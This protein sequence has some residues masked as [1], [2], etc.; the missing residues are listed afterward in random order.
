MNSNAFDSIPGNA[1]AKDYINI[2]VDNDC[3]PHALIIE[4]PEG[5]GKKAFARLIAASFGCDNEVRP[6]LC[7]DKCSRILEDISQDV[8]WIIPEKDKK[9]IGVDQIRALRESL[10]TVPGESERKF[11][12]INDASTMTEQAQNGLLKTIEEPPEFAYFLLL[13]TNAASLLP[14]VRSRAPSVRMQ[15]F[16]DMELAE[17]LPSLSK[18]ASE[19]KSSDPEAYGL[20]IRASAGCFEKALHSVS[21]LKVGKASGSVE[22]ATEVIALLES[23]SR[24]QILAC[25]LAKK[26]SRDD[27]CETVKIV[28]YALRDIFA[29]KKGCVNTPMLFFSSF[30]D[31]SDYTSSF[32]A[33]TVMK[34]YEAAKQSYLDLNNISLN[35]RIAATH[36]AD[37]LCNARDRIS[38]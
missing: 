26:P 32:T 28:C 7:C 18:K 25:L 38:F 4:G 24:A 10:Y 15:I 16:E 34:M 9:T 35:A 11:F 36:F 20:A 5:T 2:C 33:D 31:A 12:I 22:M 27:L 29:A 8:T 19:L 14:T 13:A 21:S 30:S 37:T 17:L 3:L 1:A 23:G 6:C